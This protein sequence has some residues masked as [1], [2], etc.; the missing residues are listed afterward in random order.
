MT[1]R[2]GDPSRAGNQQGLC[3]IGQGISFCASCGRPVGYRSCSYQNANG[4]Q[5]RQYVR[6]R[7]RQEGVCDAKAIPLALIHAVILTRLQPASLSALFPQQQ[8][9]ALAT[10]Q[11]RITKAIEAQQE[12]EAAVT[13]GHQQITRLLA[14]DADLIP[15]VARSIRDAEIRAATAASTRADLEHQ[16]AMLRRSQSEDAR[17]ELHSHVVDLLQSIAAGAETAT[18]RIA[19]NRA[20]RA[21]S[22]RILIDSAGQRVGLAI[23]DALTQWGP[24]HAEALAQLADGLTGVSLR[25]VFGVPVEDTF[26]AP[27]GQFS[28][29]D[30]L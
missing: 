4:R 27:D 2:N 14:S 18:Q 13:A 6:C 11:V 16:A 15:I 1:R 17:Q 21:L 7:G 3:F 26:T 9:N 5:L 12:A 28:K 19:V 29:S 23:G 22:L 24:I 30:P 8:D 20:L 25:T 10:L